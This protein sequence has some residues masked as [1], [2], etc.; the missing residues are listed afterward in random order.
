MSCLCPSFGNV[1]AYFVRLCHNAPPRPLLNDLQLETSCGSFFFA[2]QT[3]Q[4]TGRG[5]HTNGA[6]AVAAAP[7]KRLAPMPA[8]GSNKAF[9]SPADAAAV[10]LPA[11]MD[12]QAASGETLVDVEDDNMSNSTANDEEKAAATAKAASTKDVRINVA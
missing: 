8:M 7:N 2:T 11:G 1:P 9:L 5:A 3:Y 12:G 4:R 6:A 10:G